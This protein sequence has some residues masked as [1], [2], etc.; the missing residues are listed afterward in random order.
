M[1]Q[2]QALLLATFLTTFGLIVISGVALRLTSPNPTAKIVFTESAVKSNFTTTAPDAVLQ[3]PDPVAVEALIQ[4]REAAYQQALAQANQQLE[5]AYSQLNSAQQD[6]PTPATPG[7]A[8]VSTPASVVPAYAITGEIAQTIALGVVPG[9]T[10]SKPAELVA[11]EGNAAYEVQ[12]SGGVVYVEANTGQVLYNQATI[13]P[14]VIPSEQQSANF[15]PAPSTVNYDDDDH[16][17]HQEQEDD[18]E[19]DD[20]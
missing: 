13:L 16:E 3:T 19:E 12:T 4:S 7:E 9:A 20:D 15:V 5:T 8:G 11:F 17:E 1:G 2:K 6:Q 10:L 18:H 14:V